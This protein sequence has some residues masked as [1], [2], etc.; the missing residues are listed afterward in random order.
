[1]TIEEALRQFRPETVGL[2]HPKNPKETIMPL[3]EVAIIEKDAE[4]KNEKLVF[5]PK[6][7]IQASAEAAKVQ[8]VIEASGGDDGVKLAANLTVLCRSFQ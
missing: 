3:F 8:A 5:G 2:V 4:G 7:I 6:A 1:M